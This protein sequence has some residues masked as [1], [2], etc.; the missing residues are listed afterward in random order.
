MREKVLTFSR[1]FTYEL[2]KSGLLVVS[3]S[4][5]HAFMEVRFFLPSSLFVDFPEQ[6]FPFNTLTLNSQV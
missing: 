3:S 2:T 4:S 6:M 5:R 1:I